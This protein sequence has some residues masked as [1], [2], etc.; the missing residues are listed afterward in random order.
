MGSTRYTLRQKLISFG[1]DFWI[2]DEHGN[3]AYKVDGKALRLRKTLV[4]EDAHGNPLCQIQDR[5]LRIR[6][7]MEV[8]DPH[9]HPIAV[10]KKALINLLGDRWIVEFVG[11]AEL[12]VHGNVLDHE[13]TIGEGMDKIA[14]ISKKW[15]SLTDSYS[16]A[17]ESGQNDV[18]V[19]AIA[20]VIDMMAHDDDD[21]NQLQQ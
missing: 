5:P 14:E 20:V 11:G 12:H 3:H 2:D 21:D 13:Y 10:V 15:L 6:D 19:L 7:T 8:T 18:V 16:I 4:F 17:V 1:D 9:G